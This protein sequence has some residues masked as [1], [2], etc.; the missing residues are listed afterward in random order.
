M[1]VN[2]RTMR[3]WLA[4]SVLCACTKPN[5]RSCLDGLCTDPAFPFCDVD[6]TV[7]GEEN[8]CIAPD[9]TPGEFV[10]C[11]GK[12]KLTCNF[13][14]ND[15]DSTECPETCDDVVGGCRTTETR[16]PYIVFSSNRDGNNEIYRMSSDG[17]LPT[18]LTINAASDTTPSWDPLGDHIAFLSDRNGPVELFV[19]DVNGTDPRN[20][21]AGQAAEPAWSP[22]S[23]RLAFV[24][25][26]T[27]SPELYSVRV[28]GTELARLTTLGSVSAPDW[29]PD[30][31]RLIFASGIQLFLV[32]A[33]GGTATPISAGNDSGA[34]WRP[35]GTKIAYS[36]RVTFDNRD[37]F[38]SN[39]DGSG[40]VNLSN[41]MAGTE[42]DGPRWSPDGLFLT[43]T[44]GADP[45]TEIYV[46][47]V[48]G[49]RLDNVSGSPARDSGPCWAPDGTQIAFSSERSGNNDIYVVS[50]TGGA[51][52]NLTMSNGSDL[53][54]SW[55]PR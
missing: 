12:E 36:H 39:P 37:V 47:D 33:N 25:A 32:G 15:L 26:R 9:C 31:S 11:R 17:T 35:D 5:P 10:A 49:S 24:S 28:D 29:S 53:G 20:V 52:T 40:A 38:V 18:N 14:G 48:V 1:I 43:G 4:I 41:T 45:D 2:T 50:R 22:D 51:A 23:T 7:A 16:E 46:L 3:W 21:S 13:A 42:A 55:R 34:R 6:G 30:A 54:C 8:S 19:M 44:G 27:G